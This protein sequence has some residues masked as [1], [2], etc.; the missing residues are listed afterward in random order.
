MNELASEHR[1]SSKRTKD[2]HPRER[3]S[4]TWMAEYVKMQ[5]NLERKM[6]GPILSNKGKGGVMWDIDYMIQWCACPIYRK[7][8]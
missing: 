4:L 7:S 1:N 8:F 3:D 6:L 5:S 2:I